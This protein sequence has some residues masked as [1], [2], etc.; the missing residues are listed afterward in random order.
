[1]T[2]PCM[3]ELI[4]TTQATDRHPQTHAQRLPD[5]HREQRAGSRREPSDVCSTT[6]AE[7]EAIVC[8]VNVM[9][10]AKNKTNAHTS[11]PVE[12]VQ[13]TLEYARGPCEYAKSI[14]SAQSAASESMHRQTNAGRVCVCAELHG[15]SPVMFF[16]VTRRPIGP[17]QL[18][19]SPIGGSRSRRPN[20]T[21]QC[22]C[23]PVRVCLCF[24]YFMHSTFPH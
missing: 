22:R 2:A 20:C 12:R 1:M 13:C 24:A 5:K 9:R 8:I 17:V 14:A 16:F 18:F 3:A 19:R 11:A 7:V 10:S 4:R 23:V 21:T 6:D 15:C